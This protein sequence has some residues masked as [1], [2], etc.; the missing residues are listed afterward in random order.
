MWFNSIALST[1]N[2]F[3]GELCKIVANSIPSPRCRNSAVTYICLDINHPR[4]PPLESGGR[5]LLRVRVIQPLK[6]YSRWKEQRLPESR[7][8]SRPQ[9]LNK[10]GHW[11]IVGDK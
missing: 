6:N 1:L 2:S 10:I 3:T 8:A 9:K 5:A 7:D 11:R 4:L